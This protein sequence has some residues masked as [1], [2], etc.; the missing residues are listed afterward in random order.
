VHWSVEAAE[1]REKDGGDERIIKNIFGGVM[2]EPSEVHFCGGE[3]NKKEDIMDLSLPLTNAVTS[4]EEALSCYF[5]SQLLEDGD[6]VYRCQNCKNLTPAQMQMSIFKPPNVLVI[7]LNRFAMD[8]YGSS[9]KINRNISFKQRL[10]LDNYLS[11]GADQEKYNINTDYYSLFATIIHSGF[12]QDSG[13][14]YAYVKNLEDDSWH[15]CND[16]NVSP[17]SEQEVLSDQQVYL[18]FFIR[19]ETGLKSYSDCNGGDFAEDVF[20]DS[21]D[22][23][24]FEFDDYFAAHRD[25]RG[26]DIYSK[27]ESEFELKDEHIFAGGDG[28]EDQCVFAGW[29]NVEV[30]SDEWVKDEF[31]DLVIREKLIKQIC[32]TAQQNKTSKVIRKS[33]QNG[34]LELD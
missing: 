28:V 20:S 8:D 34:V 19:R 1:L 5:A 22:V 27:D 17:V 14:Y 29:E 21:N 13:H 31:E 24:Q 16:A 18:L 11:A 7:Q 30:E 2:Q 4:L 9:I 3:S 6:N 32:V 25:G 23:L 12:S 15:C 33:S 10:G 26:I